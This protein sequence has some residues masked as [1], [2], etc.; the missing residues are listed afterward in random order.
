MLELHLAPFLL[1]TVLVPPLLIMALAFLMPGLPR[2][3][4]T[5][6]GPPVLAIAIAQGLAAGLVLYVMAGTGGIWSYKDAGWLM[7]GTTATIA[8]SLV[9]ATTGGLYAGAA[10]MLAVVPAARVRA[11]W[12]LASAVAAIGAAATLLAAAATVFFSLTRVI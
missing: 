3:R 10:L 4:A 12:L 6:W 7:A 8:T 1:P 2:T 5:T 9:G 11:P